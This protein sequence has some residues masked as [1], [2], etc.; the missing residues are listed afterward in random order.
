MPVRANL[1]VEKRAR[2]DRS[3]NTL[4]RVGTPADDYVSNRTTIRM[5]M[6]TSKT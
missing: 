4:N 6:I 2:V 3:D 1:G 5:R